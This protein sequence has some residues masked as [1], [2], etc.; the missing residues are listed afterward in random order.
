MPITK[1]QVDAFKQAILEFE[2]AYSRYVVEMTQ[3]YNKPVLGVSL[4][5]DGLSK[6]LYRYDDL[7][8]KGV[9]FA[10]PERAVK[11]LAAM[12]QYQ[13][14]CRDHGDKYPG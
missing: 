4:L 2:D 9:F 6:T 14:W 11:A 10:S 7:D 13:K 3:T 1:E 5:T 8:Y 12:Y